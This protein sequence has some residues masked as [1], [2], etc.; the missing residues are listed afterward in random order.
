MEI[1]INSRY[2]HYKGGE[3]IVLALAKHTETMEN[4]VV[5]QA[6]YG[7]NDIWCRPLSMW[8]D[9]IDY[10]GKKIKRFELIEE[11]NG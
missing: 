6:L 8:N 11:N 9:I 1:K 3:Y 10:N 5:Y 2:R 4:M 7:N